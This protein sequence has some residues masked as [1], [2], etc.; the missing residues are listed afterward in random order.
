MSCT[1]FVRTEVSLHIAGSGYLSKE[2]NEV[3]NGS[4]ARDEVAPLPSYRERGTHTFPFIATW[5]KE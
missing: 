1:T 5:T 2:D 3:E 4:M